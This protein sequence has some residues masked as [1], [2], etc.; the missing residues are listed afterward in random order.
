M[1][2][3]QKHVVIGA[4]F[5]FTTAALAGDM[6]GSKS[7]GTWVAGSFAQTNI[8]CLQ[9]W[10]CDSGAVL[11][12]P[13]TLLVTTKNT[14]TWGTCNAAGGPADSCNTCSAVKPNEACEYWLEKK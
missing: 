13:D 4:T 14:N 5:I 8:K 2:N 1:T 11:H 9:A 3:W 6:V 7:P 10:V 12:S